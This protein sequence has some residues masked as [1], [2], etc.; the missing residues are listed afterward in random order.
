[1][2][3]RDR[4]LLAGTGLFLRSLERVRDV[5]PG[6]NPEGV[7]TGITVL[8]PAKYKD[9]KN[10][11]A[12]AAS[13][14]SKLRNSPQVEM[15]AAAF[16]IPFSG[17]NWHSSFRI[18]G[19]TQ[20]PDEPEP[21]GGNRFVSPDYFKLMGIPLVKGRYFTEADREGGMRVAIVDT[22]LA[23]VFFKDEDPIGHR[24][25]RGGGD[26]FTLSLIHI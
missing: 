22:K 9:D 20:S 24:I 17:A 7:L 4:V 5:K 18:E 6:F 1:M 2:C 21:H 12:F 8:P 15:A 3:I 13:V 14:I 16:P 11:A 26:P 19:R 23:S 10:R 25:S